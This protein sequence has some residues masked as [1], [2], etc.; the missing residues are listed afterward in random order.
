MPNEFFVPTYS[1]DIIYRGQDN[2]RCLTDE[3]DTIEWN[4]SDLYN[5]V[6]AKANINHNHSNYSLSTHTH[7]EYSVVEHEHPDYAFLDHDHEEYAD[8]NHNHS[9][10]ELAINNVKGLF[11]NPN[12]LINGDFQVWQRGTSFSNIANKYSADRWIIKNAKGNTS[13]VERS[14]DVPIAVPVQYSM[15][16]QETLNENS[17]LR[18]YFENAM[19]GTYTLSFWYKNDVEINSYIYDNNTLVHLFKLEPSSI[20]TRKTFTFYATSMTFLNIIQ[21]MKVGNAYIAAVKLEQ[22]TTATPFI[23]RTYREELRMCQR[24][25]DIV[26]GV[27][28]M[29]G[30]QS[31]ENKSYGF[32]VP[33]AITNMR[34]TPA[35]S[36]HGT[37]TV[38]STAGICVRSTSTAVLTG[39]TFSYTVRNGEVLITAT[40]GSTLPKN[41]YEVQLY[42]NN[43]FQLHLDAEIY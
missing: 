36:A 37:T 23:P 34:T 15:H 16:I 7:A 11:S 10:Y 12:L 17:Y 27:R 6:A 18:Y 2:S 40:S 38:N 19:R 41:G 4:V 29:G 32:S 25:F 24:Y 14:T 1:S 30:E 13:L 43:N 26:S 31:N 39:F 28:I 35:V 9:E 42:M 8:V 20:W 5:T 3:L 22:G 33:K 21:A